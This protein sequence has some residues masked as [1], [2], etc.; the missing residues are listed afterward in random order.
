M[1]SLGVSF[2]FVK[3]PVTNFAKSTAFYREVLGL[4][5]DFAVEAY[6]WAQYRAGNAYVCIYTV[7]VSSFPADELQVKVKTG[8]DTGIQLR[9]KD[10]SK[11][12][13]LVK[14]RGG[15]VSDLRTGDDG[16][17]GFGVSD[18]D[19]NTLSIAQVPKT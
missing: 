9:V 1:K 4:E 17:I 13:T 16:T 10:A 3:I 8:I 5:E 12:Y 6:G 11:A 2:G 7:G 14:A 15:K 18:P 19:G